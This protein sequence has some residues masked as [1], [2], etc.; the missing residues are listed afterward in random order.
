[1]QKKLSQIVYKQFDVFVFFNRLENE[2]KYEFIHWL[3]QRFKIV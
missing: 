1:M 3:Y 2:R